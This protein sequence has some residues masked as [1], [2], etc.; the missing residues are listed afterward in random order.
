MAWKL[1]ENGINHIDRSNER[2]GITDRID[3]TEL[4]EPEGYNATE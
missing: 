2:N 1:W 3:L 4:F